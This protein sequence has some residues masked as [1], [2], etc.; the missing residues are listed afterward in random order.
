M[1]SAIVM[2]PVL[3]PLLTAVLLM[4]FSGRLRLQQMLSLGSGALLLATALVIA[5]RTARGSIL[6]LAVGSWSPRVGIV[7]V[8][9]ALAALMLLFAA[10]VAMATLA[11]APGSLRG[12]RE[13]R[14]FYPLQQLLMAG[15]NGSLVT[16]D[17]FNLFVFFEI[18]LLSSFALISLGTRAMGLR[19]AF[20]YVVVNL[21]ASA[22]LLG[23]VGAVY[24][25]TGTV[26]MAELALRVREGGLPG[27]FWGSAALVLVVF[28]A[29]AALVPVFFWLP[30][31]YP[32]ASVAVNGLF[33]GLLTKVGVYT[34][35]RSVP[36][37]GAAAPGG[38]Q[39]ALLVIA[40]ATMVVGVVGALGRSSIR[41]ILSFH[42]VSQVGYMIFGLAVFTPLAVAAGL[43]HTIHNMVAKTALIFAGGIAEGIGGS[44]KLG[45]VR[46]LA[47]T[48]PWVAAG[49][50]V[51]AMSLAGLPAL[52]GFWGKLLL[53]VG[54][55][56]AGAFAVTAISLA[57]GLL[58]LASMLKIWTA[59]FWG[60]PTGERM[61]QVRSDRGMVGA[62]LGLSALTVILGLA[63]APVFTY[64]ERTAT[65]L[66]EVAPYVDAVL[67]RPALSPIAGER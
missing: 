20:A 44:G 5:V 56:R 30:D 66:L 67:G 26:N 29:K 63:V 6:V 46:G 16:G 37:V 45:D 48:H 53:V 21:V 62:T 23:G 33:A 42:I 7:W 39:S 40:A 49:F 22:L 35:F 3:L 2:I 55:F 13:Q 28:M 1:T 24:G 17:F 60:E 41:G 61:P 54:G 18:M 9:D 4:P 14:S 31:A 32:K 43:F 34:L 27:V 12:A 59:V 47:R 11:Y 58:T 36:L 15:V 50:F 10:I 52:S 8:T 57:V 64:L 51:P 19:Q 65:A 38:L 25:T